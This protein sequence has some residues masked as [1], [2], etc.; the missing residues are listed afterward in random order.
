MPPSRSPKV[1]ENPHDGGSYMDSQVRLVA[2][3]EKRRTEAPVDRRWRP[4]R[5]SRA[6]RVLA[7]APS[8]RPRSGCLSSCGRAASRG[9]G[10]GRRSGGA[11]D[12]SPTILDL[13][14]SRRRAADGTACARAGER[15]A[16]YM[17]TMMATR[18]RWAPPTP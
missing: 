8:V 17:E 4:R 18:Y 2:A 10:R 12:I 16:I 14:H 7:R 15:R 6:L 5:A 13:L 11:G 1:R 9:P 3:L